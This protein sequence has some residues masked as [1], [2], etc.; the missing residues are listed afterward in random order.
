MKQITKPEKLPEWFT[1]LGL[2]AAIST[3]DLAELLGMPVRKLQR[4]LP[5]IPTIQAKLDL[6]KN[7]PKYWAKQTIVE[8]LETLPTTETK[9]ETKCQN[10]I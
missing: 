8:W 4:N 5:N 7:M 6:P 10:I 9:G 1:I 2:K 3:R